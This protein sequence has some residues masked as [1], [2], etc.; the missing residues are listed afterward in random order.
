LTS[1][2]WTPLGQAIPDENGAA[3]FFDAG[4]PLTNSLRFYRAHQ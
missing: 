4:S 3:K 1:T 2:N